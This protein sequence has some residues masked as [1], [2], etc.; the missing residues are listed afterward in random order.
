[1]SGRMVALERT[2]PFGGVSATS[3]PALILPARK[4]HR[5]CR[6]MGEGSPAEGDTL[7]TP[8]VERFLTGRNPGRA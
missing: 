6:A 7:R 8:R 2:N 3:E 1:V 4:R 5:V